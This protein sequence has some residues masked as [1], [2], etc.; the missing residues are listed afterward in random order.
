[1]IDYNRAKQ[2]KD[3]NG[4]LS[5][6]YIMPFVKYT[7]SQITVVDNVLTEF[8]FTYIYDM[9]PI[10][11]SSFKEDVEEE[12]GGVSFS[13]SGGFKVS[14]MF[15]EDD[16][17]SLAQMDFRIIV[18]DN[19]NQLRLLGLNTGLVI[20][21][22]KDTGS[23][24]ADFNGFDFSYSTKELNTAPFLSNLDSFEFKDMIQELLQYEL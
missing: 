1:M 17:K 20:K 6:L 11:I 13:I 7:R 15:S 2:C 22:N 5:L 16:F 18:K 9:K 12:D 21:Y 23:N 8:P 3:S 4:G 19:N 14:K 10:S 24:R